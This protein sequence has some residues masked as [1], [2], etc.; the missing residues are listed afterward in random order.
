[1]RV[2]IISVHP[3]D[4]TLG[5]GGTIL[6][7]KARG[8]DLHWLI[9]TE[10]FEPDWSADVLAKKAR[11]VEQVAEAYG[12]KQFYKA[13]FHTTRL[14]NLPQ[15]TLI[16]GIRTVIATVKP[17]VIY[18]VHAGDVHTDHLA[19]FTATLS[20]VKSFYMQHWGVR[21]ILSYETLSSTEAAPPQHYRAFVPNVYNDITPYLEQKQ[22]IMKLYSS[23]AQSALAP[24]GNSAIE[25]LAR[26]RGASID[27]KYAEAFMLI[28]E[29]MA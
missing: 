29:V 2:L 9:A 14:D 5:C 20:V 17:E 26:F 3:D 25:A 19:I 22:N 7:H 11:E 10:G 6:K 18:L 23:E 8:D 21:R 27:V 28:R 15:S 1:M 16:D 13:G 24:R 4:E 12:I